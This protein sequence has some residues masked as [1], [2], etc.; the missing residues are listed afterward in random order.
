MQSNQ[1]V[2]TK[3]AKEKRCAM[4]NSAIRKVKKEAQKILIKEFPNPENK[5]E[6]ELFIK[7]W[8]A[9]TDSLNGTFGSFRDYKIAF[10]HLVNTI[11]HY[12]ETFGWSISVPTY[13]FIHK[14]EKQLRTGEW[15]KQAWALQHS[16]QSWFNDYINSTEENSAEQLYQALML[17]FMCHSGHCNIHLVSTFSSMLTKPIKLSVS[18]GAP[19]IALEISAK[20]FNTNIR[21][22]DTVKTQYTCYLSPFTQGLIRLWNRLDLTA[23]RPKLDNNQIYHAITKGLDKSARLFPT[24]LN[25]MTSV[26]ISITEQL[27]GVGIGQA[28]VEYAIG[29]TKSYSLPSENQVR[30]DQPKIAQCPHTLFYSSNSNQQNIGS[31]NTQNKT[32]ASS[33]LLKLLTK[34]IKQDDPKTKLSSEKLHQRLDHIVAIGLPLNQEVL[35]RWLLTKIQ[36]CGA[37]TIR[38]YHSSLTR[39]WLNATNGIQINDMDSADFEDIYMTLIDEIEKSSRKVYVAERLSQLHGFAV[40]NYGFPPLVNSLIQEVKSKHT[41]AGFIDEALFTG[42]LQQVELISDLNPEEKNTVKSILIFAYRGGL[43]LSEIV[44][45]RLCDIEHSSTG[46]LEIRNNK[47]G[48]NKTAAARRRIPLMLLLLPHEKL[49]IDEHLRYKA[50]MSKTNK[51]LIFTLGQD[52]HKPI[53][54]M[55]ISTFVAQTLRTLSGLD[56]LVFHHLRHSCL[57]RLQIMLEIHNTHSLLPNV[58]SYPANIQTKIL[59]QICGKSVRNRY[60]AIAAFAGHS[61]PATCFNNYFHFTDWIIGYKL[62][63]AKVPISREVAVR[64]GLCSRREY[65]K[66]KSEKDDLYPID[67]QSYLSQKLQPKKLKTMIVKQTTTSFAPPSKKQPQRYSFNLCYTVLEHIQEGYDITEVA[68]KFRIEPTV[69]NHWIENA[70]HLKTLKTSVKTRETSRLFTNN[71]TSKLLPPKCNTDQELALIDKIIIK[72]RSQY[73]TQKKGMKWAVKFALDHCN[74]NQSGIYF[75]KPAELY[76]FIKVMKFAIPKSHWRAITLSIE[77][78]PIKNE[79]SAAYAGVRSKKGK[80]ASATGRIGRGAVRLELRHPDEDKIK[81]KRGNKQFS[82]NAL[83]YFFHMMWIMTGD[84]KNK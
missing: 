19:F 25:K 15:L 75:N 65:V 51:R 56:F 9:I 70:N 62:A 61:S 69:I 17:S 29:H 47:Y 49:I 39:R 23:W 36:T 45:L 81:E 2:I 72:I 13:L 79:W 82:S 35:V 14:P 31:G 80:K 28:L 84:V 71:R 30:V 11:E 83:I 21:C 74:S 41:R 12:R 8:A 37:S 46:W 1:N 63:Y 54:N 76:H 78:S 3:D 58:V 5:P 6:W 4:R 57:S 40:A 68:S 66:L 24:T 26:A 27:P 20:G 10:N 60:Y 48:N 7:K 44:K 73:K 67:F 43:R 50:S 59:Y 33:E 34:A 38:T 52:E 22:G 53:D 16:Y 77:Q 64:L 18:A 42:L 55:L 32:H